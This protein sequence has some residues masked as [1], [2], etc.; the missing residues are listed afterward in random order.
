MN[1]VKALE[2]VQ[3]ILTN[4][5]WNAE[6]YQKLLEANKRVIHAVRKQ[7]LANSKM[8]RA[9]KAAQVFLL[10]DELYAKTKTLRGTIQE[11]INEGALDIPPAAPPMK[12]Y[13]PSVARKEPLFCPECSQRMIYNYR[14]FSAHLIRAHAVAQSA[15]AEL[16][17]AAKAAR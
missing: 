5:P 17:V 8:L 14:S 2:A 6:L 3:D 15:I 7:N 4:E 12:P 9:L 11:A 13:R 10:S 16:W 1:P